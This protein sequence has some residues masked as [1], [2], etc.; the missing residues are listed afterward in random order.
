[1]AI[2]SEEL[3]VGVWKHSK[4]EVFFSFF[5]NGGMYFKFPLAKGVHEISGKY[6]LMD[7][8]L[9]KIEIDQQY[10]TISGKP[11][12]T[13][14]QVLKVTVHEDRIIFHN[15]RINESYEQVFTRIK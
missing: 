11:L 14:P 8:N 9:L 4:D 10:G 7:E 13:N 6:K 1:M 3:I 2:S 5:K 15:L 12:F